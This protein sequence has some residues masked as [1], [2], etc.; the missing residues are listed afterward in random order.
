[1]EYPRRWIAI[2]ARTPA[3][4]RDFV[5]EGPGGLLRNTPPAERPDWEPSKRRLT[6][7]NNSWATIVS[8]EAPDQLRGYSGDTAWLDE[9][10]KY[11]NPQ[12][13]WDNLQF[14]MREASSDRPRVLITTTP[15]PISALIAIEKMPGT[16]VVQGSSWENKSHLDP[17]WF[18]D[19]LSVYAGTRLGRQEIEAEILSDVPGALWTRE[20]LDK[21]RFQ[22]G[23]ITEI[24]K[25][26]APLPMEHSA[27]VVGVW[28][29]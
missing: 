1:M 25:G 3:D 18:T 15:R 13:V 11:A 10:G 23:P 7:S 6:W 8:D 20:M 12:A 27:S 2:V 24:R 19:V 21:C 26:H 16:V 14:G 4:A 5:V 28:A 29:G 17:K 22:C 9:F